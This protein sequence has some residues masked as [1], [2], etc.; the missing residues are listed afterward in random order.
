MV[1]FLRSL[2]PAALSLLATVVPAAEDRAVVVL[3][4][5]GWIPALAATGITAESVPDLPALIRR[6][7][8]DP[9]PHFVIATA[10]DSDSRLALVCQAMAGLAPSP[11]IAVGP[12]GRRLLNGSGTPSEAILVVT[13]PTDAATVAA[14]VRR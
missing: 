14:I 11:W 9:P 8:Q 7:E 3:G 6:C 12:D 13:G 1:P 10:A 4:D 2:L 5:G